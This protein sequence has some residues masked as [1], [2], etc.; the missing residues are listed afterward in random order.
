MLL[1]I[2]KNRTVSSSG[3]WGTKNENNYEILN[4]EFPEELEEYNKRIVYYLGNQ[5]VWDPIIDNKAILTNAITTKGSV[6]AYIWCTKS[7][8]AYETD[9]DFRTQIFVMNFFENDNADGIVPTPEQVDGFNTMLT[10]MNEKIE[11]INELETTIEN[12]ETQRQENEET[13]Q[14]NEST[15][16]DNEQTRQEQEADRERR[17]NEA[18][19]QITDMTQAYNQNAINKTNEFNAVVN[20]QKDYIEGV[21]A[22][23]VNKVAQK[24][25]QALGSINTTTQFALQNIS[26][27]QE[28]G[29]SAVESASSQATTT[30]NNNATSKTNTFNSNAENKTTAFNNNATQKTTDFDNNA[31]SKTTTFNE[32][33]TSKTNDF[34]D[35]ATA[36]TTAFN[37]NAQAKTEA[38]DEHTAEMQQEI[39]ELS[40]NMPWAEIEQGTYLDITDSAKY[41]KNKMKVFGNTEQASYTGVQ[42][43]DLSNLAN[44]SASNIDITVN[45]DKTFKI[46]GTASA[47]F[48]WNTNL[49]HSIVLDGDYTIVLK[50]IKNLSSNTFTFGLG[51]GNSISG[52]T[53]QNLSETGINVTNF[54]V[55][56]KTVTQTRCYVNRYNSFNNSEFQF[57]LVKGTYTAETI[58]DYEPYV[59]GVPAPNSDY[60]Q[61]IHIVTG[62]NTI[63][64][65]GI[66]LFDDSVEKKNA[67]PSSWASSIGNEVVY[68]NSSATYSY[69]NCTYLEKGETYTLSW[70]Q[71]VTPESAN[72]RIG[73]LVDSNDIVLETITTWRNGVNNINITPT[74]SGYLI[75]SIDINA[76]DMQIEKGSTA[77]DYQPYYHA[78]Y[79][80]NL[81]S[82]ELCKIGDYQDYFY[83]ENGNWYKHGAVNKVVLNGS[84]AYNYTNSQPTDTNL[85]SITHNLLSRLLGLNPIKTNYFKYEGAHGVITN[86][87]YECCWVNSG[88]HQIGFITKQTSVDNFK[89][90]L[91][92]HNTAVYYVLQTPTSTQIT[93][94]T[95]IAQL[96]VIYNHLALV[97]G[98][99]HIT[100]TPSDLAPYVTLNYMQD[101]PSKLDNLDSRL[102]L[103]E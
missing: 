59:G 25:N 42:L 44:R 15:R 37:E 27:A 81:G 99:N 7:D 73:V 62:N 41:S 29:V 69:I 93:D 1:K 103:L 84:E 98:T 80:I 82:L 12:A 50:C 11:E 3:T 60:P 63:G 71:E 57:Y 47:G 96:E 51:N 45:P 2:F 24:G 87:K 39:D 64:V 77:T 58:P 72:E 46:N 95:L 21:G 75:L 14:E 61:N 67:Y 49:P 86:A 32:N 17:T 102:A 22:T 19:G 36:K 85:K 78:D 18:I 10:A 94:E 100:I 65:Q 28:T 74:N 31:S 6:K 52:T 23:Q 40:A 101:L 89:T 68:N 43:L 16:Q 38:F 88:T 35:N 34:N 4:F 30:F 33:A 8:E 53:V 26:H 20:E 9:V 92:T 66:N 56:N 13:R 55:S 90:W 5:K 79:P 54:S 97:K 83:K 48:S 76:T 91:S 70:K